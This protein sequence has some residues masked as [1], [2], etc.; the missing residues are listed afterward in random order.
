MTVLDSSV[1]MSQNFTERS[2]ATDARIL[3]SGEKA[4]AAQ[5]EMAK[6]RER[7]N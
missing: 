1:S 4:R 6:R 3:L 5:A 2:G 7:N